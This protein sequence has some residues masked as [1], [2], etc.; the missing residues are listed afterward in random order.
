M[1]DELIS[2]F[3]V[4]DITVTGTAGVTTASNFSGGVNGTGRF[5]EFDVV[6]GSLDGTVIVSIAADVAQD[7]TGNSNTAS[8]PYTLTID[9]TPPVISLTGDATLTIAMGTTY[10]D[11]GAMASDI[12][13]GD[14]THSI[15][16]SITRDGA[17]VAAVNVALSGTYIITYAVSDAAGNMATAV[18]RTVTV[19]EAI[20]PSSNAFQA[21]SAGNKITGTFAG[22]QLTVNGAAPDDFTLSGAGGT[23]VTGI[24]IDPNNVAALIL[25]LSGNI[26]KDATVTLAYT[27]TVGNISGVSTATNNGI[28]INFANANVD[29]SN[30][31]T[32]P[33]LAAFTT[34]GSL[35]AFVGTEIELITIANSGSAATFNIS[36]DLPAG[37]S[38]DLNTGAI[39]GTP[40][41]AA[42]EVTYTI[43]ATNSSGTDD[44]T[45]T[46]T[47]NEAAPRITIRPPEITATVG[48]AIMPTEIL[49]IG[50]G[51]VARYSIDPTISN[52]LLFDTT[53]GIISGT[54]MAVA[55]EITYTITATNSGGDG[56]ATIAVTVNPADT[57]R[58]G[59][60]ISS[61][62]VSA[63]IANGDILNAAKLRDGTTLQYEV[64]FD[65]FISGF[66]IGDITVTGTAGVTTASNFSGGVNGTGRFFRF[67]VVK[68]SLDGTVIVSIA[69]DVVEDATGNSNTASTPYTL[70]IDTTPP[71]IT[72]TGANPQ[73]IELGTGYTELGA[74]T[75]D[76][77]EVS[78]DSSAFTDAVGTYTITY[79]ATDGTNQA[80]PV[81]RTVHVVDTTAPIITL[82]GVNPQTIEL[83]AGYTEL[84]ATADDGSEV[85][86]DSSAFTDTVGTYIITYTAT[87]GTN[88]A[89]RVIRTVNVVG[90]TASN[91]QSNA[92]WRCFDFDF[93]SRMCVESK[94]VNSGDNVKVQFSAEA[95]LIDPSGST[96]VKQFTWVQTAGP[97]VTTRDFT[98]DLDHFA[99]EAT[100]TKGSFFFTAPDRLQE[101][102]MHFRITTEVD[103]RGQ[104]NVSASMTLA[105]TV[106]KNNKA[107]IITSLGGSDEAALHV[108][109][110]GG[111]FV[112]K[113][114]AT[115]ENNDAL[116]YLIAQERDYEDFNI[117]AKSGVVTY[118]G[119]PVPGS[120]ST[121][122]VKVTD[123]DATDEQLINI[124]VV[125]PSDV[126]LPENTQAVA[127]IT[128]RIAPPAGAN[129]V[130]SLLEH[131]ATLFTITQQGALRF[132][133]A[134]IPDYENP[135]D[136][137]GNIDQN[138]DQVYQVVVRMTVNNVYLD[139]QIIRVTITNL[140]PRITSP[141][142]SDSG[143][144]TLYLL[145]GTNHVTT[146]IAED[147]DNNDPST[148]SI[149]ETSVDETF[150]INST[151]GFLG[152]F[153]NKLPPEASTFT[154]KVKAAITAAAS[155]T[156]LIN[157]VIV[158]DTNITLPENTQEVAQITPTTTP[159]AGANLVYSVS[160]YDSGVFEITA[161]GIL[162][163]KDEYI[164]DY[165]IPKDDR[166]GVRTNGN[167]DY[168]TLVTVSDGGS[169]TNAQL[170]KVAVTDVNDAPRITSSSTFTVAENQSAVATLTATDT[171]AGDAATFSETIIGADAEAFTLTPAGVL[172]FNSN[173]IPD[174]ETKH[175]YSITVTAND[176]NGGSGTQD[177]TITITNVNEAPVIT[178]QN[179]ASEF[180]LDL[181]ENTQAVAIITATDVD[182][183]TTLIYSL[184]QHDS[185]VYDITQDGVLTFKSE[186][187][188]NYEIPR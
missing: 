84:G 10:A 40:T 15:T 4:G 83:G 70:T 123:G 50:G 111:S 8:T 106:R 114:T 151:T 29:T 68:G 140:A 71:I 136:S 42:S 63:N 43:T 164:P 35:T 108:L 127:Q 21:T 105:I 157:I 94:T 28:I 181:D 122:K 139:A 156:L 39:S 179:G 1:F 12:I 82:T 30:I 128:P 186:Y 115:D 118:R 62:P 172:T 87:D 54:P 5:F 144:A 52:G 125:N 150:Y 79:T 166:N 60:T 173:S 141:P 46:I 13:D 65:E 103:V 117:D 187:I 155:D 55:S 77:S 121:I 17:A 56:T 100:N 182:A 137:R 145:T 91:A 51:P 3:D 9:T 170:I 98:E 177:I 112:T 162:R 14:I 163:F 48:T 58:P 85:S 184:S 97:T 147:L 95:N 45:V 178:F 38:I 107:P 36:P 88:Q 69:A 6:N 171:D 90:T 158:S 33:E 61:F 64:I 16:T 169:F 185:G 174:F 92:V 188:P 165:E 148:Y 146:V 66:E 23:T 72:L 120:V 102:I 7:A 99:V 18:T 109:G 138:G 81:T 67:D 31:V 19:V 86:I 20:S 32:A 104:A 74:T 89:T 101:T 76:G 152:I 113:V 132:K 57:T 59:V 130:Y 134:Y 75:G 180:D 161:Q 167:N 176:E 116:T 175:S 159:P 80:T 25:T 131:D 44:A 143:E 53:T 154:V 73:T 2:G 37:L 49:S 149:L 41:A 78:I 47:V 22:Q 93:E 126:T 153:D 168:W 26:A 183:N 96:R 160:E 133:S 129:L 27:R 110:G 135:R 24:A 142:R 11:A 119:N 34:P 124:R